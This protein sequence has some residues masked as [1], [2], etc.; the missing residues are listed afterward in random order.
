MHDDFRLAGLYI[1]VGFF[2][3]LLLEL[4]S[5]GVEHGHTYEEPQE[6]DHQH[7][8]SP[9]TL[10]LALLAHAF[11]DGVI[12]SSPTAAHCHHHAHST[13]GLLIG[14]I[15]HKMPE[16][17]ALAS[18]LRKLIGNKKMVFA[19]LVIFAL[20]SPFGLWG[21]YY[22]NQ[23]QWLSEHSLLILRGIV[24]GSFLHIA[25][26]IFFEASPGHQQHTSRFIASLAGAGLAVVCE[27][28]L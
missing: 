23:Q 1:L 27:F 14:V 21:S 8:I 4:F 11:L 24:T 7:N 22:C 13:D 17:F 6:A 28:S 10:M 19:Y 2:L 12:L 16:A 20:T 3:Q 5:K 26:T 9:A 15:L 25:T 18:I